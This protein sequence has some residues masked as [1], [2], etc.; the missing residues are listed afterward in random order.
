MTITDPDRI[1]Q[2]W[3]LLTVQD[4]DR[5]FGSNDGYLDEPDSH[6]LWDD[7]VPNHARIAAGDSIVLWDKKSSIGISVVES[8][9]VSRET[10]STYS[11]PRC[12]K[13]HIKARKTKSPL[14][15]CFKCGNEFDTP[16]TEIKT[17]STYTSNHE[18]AWVGLEGVLSG[19]QLR[20]VCISP[21]SQLSLRPLKWESF[22]S[23]VEESGFGHELAAPEAQSRRINGGHTSV[24]VRAR[25]GQTLFRKALIDRYGTTCAFTGECPL[26]VLEAAHLYSYASV[27]EHHEHG[28]LL[29]RRD[30]HRLFDCGKV[31]VH[32]SALVLD[33]AEELHSYSL[34][35]QLHGSKLQVRISA[36]QREWLG[37]HWKQHRME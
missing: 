36:S 13:A 3:L 20:A 5:A 2:A 21:K 28:G 22:K 14:Y 30:L 18:T 34:Y 37:A 24:L 32:P 7:T 25:K 35:Q 17:V 6:Y 15:R 23:L 19:A 9:D 1:P 8:I 26:E 11:C 16:E 31:A 10:K 29:L 33:V 12:R 4:K 27:G